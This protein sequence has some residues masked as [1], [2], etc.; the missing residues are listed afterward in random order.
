MGS[1]NA[2][3]VAVSSKGRRLAYTEVTSNWEIW[4]LDLRGSRGPAQT[5]LIASTRFDGN[6]Q[7][8]PDDERVV[9]T[10]ARSGRFEIW[11]ADADGQDLLQLTSMARS[12][13]VGSPRWS[14][15]GNRIAF[16]FL[17]EGGTRPDIYV[18]GASGG[19]PR[20][21]TRSDAP[22]VRPSWSRDGRWIYFGSHRSGQWQVWKVPADGEDEG[23]ARQVTRNG[24]Y[25]AIESP[26]G[27]H[28]YFSRR[29]SVPEDP[30]NAIWRVPVAGGDEEMVIESLLS[31]DTNWDVTAEGIYFVDRPDT[32]ASREEWVVKLLSF[33]A[34]RVTEVARLEHAPRLMG[35]AFSVSSDGRWVLVSQLKEESDL[36]LVENFR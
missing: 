3:G 17:A 15:D 18:V 22:D 33:D 31:S 11:V 5:R 30:A 29:R 2:M 7:F 23:N 12:G 10:S 36:M 19:P 8:S 4:R 21:V 27:D 34:R 1:A 16:D 13:S 20:R 24:G 26:D 6:P 9:F 14:P 35:P 32:P 28:V 25:A